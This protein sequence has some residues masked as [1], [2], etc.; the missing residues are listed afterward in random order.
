V[1]DPIDVDLLGLIVNGV[2]D[3]PIP[4]PEAITMKNPV[5]LAHTRR[6]RIN[7]KLLKLLHDPPGYWRIELPDLATGRGLNHQ[8]IH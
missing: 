6:T 3:P 5:Q 7:P 8:P 1:L 2:E 4:D